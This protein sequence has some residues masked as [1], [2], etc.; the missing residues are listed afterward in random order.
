MKL[1]RITALAALAAVVSIAAASEGQAGGGTEI[2]SCGQVV[3]TNAFLT[4]NRYCPG[5]TG[6]VV[7]AS[8]ITIDLKGF[9]LLGDRS[10]GHYGIDDTGGFDRVTVKNGVLRNFDYGIRTLVA[11]GFGVVGVLASGNSRNGMDIEGAAASLKSSTVSG[12]GDNGLVIGSKSGKVQS[13]TAVGNVESG[14]VADGAA[15]SVSSSTA[16]GNGFFGIYAH[17]DAVS[18][19]SSTASGNGGY[20]M[21]VSGDAAAISGNRAEANGFA[22][23]AAN[24]G[25]LG[26][27]VFYAV[28]PTGRNVA[29]GNDDPAECEPSFLCSAPVF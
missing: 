14:I 27:Y 2:T 12:N 1:H 17:G 26:F 8:G 22:A 21:Y 19:K 16:S 5:S 6:V 28:P 24:G 20:G 11:D 9:T 13:V 15:L 18:L 4:H 7:G 3:T 25:G 29:R 23:G 10:L